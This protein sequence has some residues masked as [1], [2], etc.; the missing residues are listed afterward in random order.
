MIS[1][2][3]VE[4]LNSQG[5]L[6]YETDIVMKCGVS[7]KGESLNFIPI[8]KETRSI[9]G[10]ENPN[11]LKLYLGRDDLS[12]RLLRATFAQ[13]IRSFSDIRRRFREQK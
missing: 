13:M 9:L 10:R 6:Q 8:F 11:L 4:N 5:N 3:F 1:L 12:C 2:E 7:C